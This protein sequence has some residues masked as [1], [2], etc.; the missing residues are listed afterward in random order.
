MEES[1]KQLGV[2]EKEAVWGKKQYLIRR[3]KEKNKFLKSVIGKIDEVVLHV[4]NSETT[5]K[6]L[7]NNGFCYCIC[8]I[9]I[10]ISLSLTLFFLFFF[11]KSWEIHSL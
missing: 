3:K 4:W 6:M 8:Y 9:S 7:Y 10:L 5:N 2:E 1:G 11:G